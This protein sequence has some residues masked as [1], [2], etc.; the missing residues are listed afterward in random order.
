MTEQLSIPPHQSADF[1]KLYKAG[2]A[3]PLPFA[4]QCGPGLLMRTTLIDLP[5]NY[6]AFAQVDMK[7]LSIGATIMKGTT[8]LLHVD[9]NSRS[10][11]AVNDVFTF[12]TDSTD[13][14]THLRSFTSL[15]LPFVVYI[16][17][18]QL[19]GGM[20]INPAAVTPFFQSLKA[21]WF[22]TPLVSPFTPFI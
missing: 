13:R 4:Y 17:K 19:V 15:D 22:P 5:G 3:V 10:E 14:P 8:P 18:S 21:V 6:K 12:T 9:A 2:V 1:R 20:H 16:P 7:T 11:A